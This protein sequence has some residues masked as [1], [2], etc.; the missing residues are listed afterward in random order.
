[1]GDIPFHGTGLNKTLYK[2]VTPPRVNSSL[3]SSR[4]N[5]EGNFHDGNRPLDVCPI[6]TNLSKRQFAYVITGLNRNYL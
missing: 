1:M 6:F 2:S 4:V 3:Q 5:D